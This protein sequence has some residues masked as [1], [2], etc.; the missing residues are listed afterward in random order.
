MYAT[1]NLPGSS[2]FEYYGPANRKECEDW[3][4]QRTL[5]LSRTEMITSILPQRVISNREAES[6]KYLDGS[7][8]IRPQLSDD[9][10]RRSFGEPCRPCGC[11]AERHYEACPGFGIE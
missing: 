3:L 10:L 5:E 9:D 6:W 4:N 11:P 1:I 7:K 8:V 2:H